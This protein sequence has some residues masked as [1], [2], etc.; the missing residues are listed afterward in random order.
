[1]TTATHGIMA[2]KFPDF[3]PNLQGI[4]Y[5]KISE[6]KNYYPQ[7]KSWWDKC[8]GVCRRGIYQYADISYSVA[9]NVSF[10][11]QWLGAYAGGQSAVQTEPII[12]YANYGWSLSNIQL[13][14]SYLKS[15]CLPKSAPKPLVY[16]TNKIWTQ[17]Y[18][19]DD[20]NLVAWNIAQEADLCISDW[21]SAQPMPVGS[22]GGVKCWEYANGKLQLKTQSSDLFT[23]NEVVVV[24]PPPDPTDPPVE[25]ST[26]CLGAIA[27][28]FGKTIVD[29]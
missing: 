28:F 21:A 11:V 25:P 8:G 20:A 16:I 14:I 29:K 15:E 26:G 27:G 12:F 22:F 6:G 1:M 18:K 7:F 23:P 24:P 9:D 2:H 4:V 10:M 17:I 3:N 5:C 13:Y 19:G